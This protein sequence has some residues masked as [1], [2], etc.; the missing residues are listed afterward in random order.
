MKLHPLR[1]LG[2]GLALTVLAACTSGNAGIE[3]NV[4]S[5]N[6]ATVGTL[7][8]AVGTANIAGFGTGLNVVATF[9]QANGATAVLVDS[10][11]IVGPTGFVVPAVATAGKDAGTNTINSTPQSLTANTAST[12]GQAGGL[13]G[14][15]FAPANI[16]TF[17]TANVPKASYSATTAVSSSSSSSAVAGAG[18][19]ALGNAYAQ[20]LY[21]GVAKYAFIG[22]PPAFPQG[23]DGTYPAGFVGYLEDFTT[24]AAAPIAGAYTLNVNVPMATGSGQNFTASATLGSVV[25]AIATFVTPTFAPDGAGGGSLAVALPAGATSAMV[26][27]IDLGPGACHG[28]AGFVAY[29]ATVTASGA[30]AIPDMVGPPS[31]AGVASKSLCTGDAYVI[32]A[33]AFDYAAF[34]N[35]YPQSTAQ[36]PTVSGQ[37]DLSMS[38]QSAP[39][40][41]P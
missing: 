3:P 18:S 11:Q 29:T 12:F 38:A 36:N 7:T 40:T 6:P 22:G 26:N 30:A 27:L 31:A 8:F 37:A 32:N 33:V 23:R 19:I 13:F 25:P 16:S 21:G 2:S 4:V 1:A 5:V 14:N 34:A 24:F 10:P 20:P 39:A 41:A 17:A 35:D 28:I 15:G 9:R